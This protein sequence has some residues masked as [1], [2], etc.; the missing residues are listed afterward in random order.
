MMAGAAHRPAYF[1]RTL[2]G[3]TTEHG[4]V[5]YALFREAPVPTPDLVAGVG[6]FPLGYRPTGNAG[7]VLADRTSD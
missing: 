7:E 4:V 3:A 2:G 6:A 1:M 5:V